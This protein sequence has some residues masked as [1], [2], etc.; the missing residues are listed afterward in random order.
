MK[1]REQ[2]SWASS[3]G[4]GK[5]VICS[6]AFN[7]RLG[8]VRIFNHCVVFEQEGIGVDGGCHVAYF[9]DISSTAAVVDG[10]YVT[11]DGLQVSDAVRVFK[12]LKTGAEPRKSRRSDL[13]QVHH[14]VGA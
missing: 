14:D 8:Y 7:E 11:R 1:A 6:I 5:I 12:P 3:W 10:G 4:S 2:A 13:G 9:G